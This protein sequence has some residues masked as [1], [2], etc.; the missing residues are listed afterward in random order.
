MLE[1]LI[2]RA[3][4][5]KM[6]ERAARQRTREGFLWPGIVQPIEEVYGRSLGFGN[7]GISIGEN[8][9]EAPERAA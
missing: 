8:P 2:S 1:L 3:R 7:R 4:V 6:A 9:G 5:R